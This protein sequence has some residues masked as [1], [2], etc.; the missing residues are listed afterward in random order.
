M[1][2][3]S[4]KKIIC[5]IVIIIALSRLDTIL[6]FIRN[7]CTGIY[8]NF[9]PLRNCSEEGKFIVTAAFLFLCFLIVW[10]LVLLKMK[11]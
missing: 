10:K 9:E 1:P 6:A 2:E 3:I 5:V 11:K 7:I 4:L 8:D